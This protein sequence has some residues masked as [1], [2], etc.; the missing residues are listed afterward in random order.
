M[1]RFLPKPAV[2]LTT[3][4]LSASLFTNSVAKANELRQNYSPA[5]ELTTNTISHI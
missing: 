1:K 3:T 4:I 2:L 5:A